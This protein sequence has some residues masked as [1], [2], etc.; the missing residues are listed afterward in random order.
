MKVQILGASGGIGGPARTTSLLVDNDILIDAGTGLGELSLAAMKSIDHVF[1]THSHLDHIACLPFMMDSVGAER[2]KPITVHAQ[3]VTL[4]GLQTHL[5]NG[6]LWPDFAR[7]PTPEAPF[8]RYETLAPGA[9]YTIGARRL[10][11]VPVTHAVPA[12]GYL[13][14]GP[15]GSIAFSG[16]TTTTDDFWRV[17]NGCDDLKHV[18]IE[19][20][21]LDEDEYLAR[22]SKHMCPLLVAQDLK[23][24]KTGPQVHITHLMPGA[25]D[26]IMGEIARHIPKNTP[27]RLMRGEVL[28]F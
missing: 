5:F 11:S 27:R 18:I 14:R 1:L 23:K 26:E 19:T 8:M 6:V 17:L 16:D 7:I 2:G 12:V 24:L 9:E 10:R 3:E 21:F 22:I 4:S 28:E 15:T 20:S 25:E 13:V